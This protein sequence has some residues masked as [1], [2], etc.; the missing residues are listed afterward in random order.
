MTSEDFFRP[1]LSGV[2]ISKVS[3]C[4]NTPSWWMPLSWAKAFRPTI[5]LLYCTGKA[6]TR[7][8]SFEARVR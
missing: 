8:T 4:F 6:V 7:E 1:T 2:M 5:A 3:A